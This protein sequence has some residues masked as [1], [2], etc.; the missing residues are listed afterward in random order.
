MK[1]ISFKR[2]NSGFTLIEIIVTLVIGAILAAILVTYMGTHLK[3]STIPLLRVQHSTGLLQVFENITADYNKLNAQD[4]NNSTSVA[5]S[6]LLTNIN[7]GNDPDKVPFYGTYTIVY[8]NY[9]SFDDNGNEILDSTE[10]RILKVSLKNGD[11]VL[12]TLF[13]K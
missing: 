8:N 9:I 6:T 10:G 5:L 11:L 7:N 13:T 3:N 4:I 1:I 2:S 12:T